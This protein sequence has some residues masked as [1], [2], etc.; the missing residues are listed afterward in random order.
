MSAWLKKEKVE[1]GK[2]KYG[3]RSMGE[4]MKVYICEPKQGPILGEYD[5]SIEEEERPNECLKEWFESA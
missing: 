3:Q 5:E 4:E 2:A 1:I